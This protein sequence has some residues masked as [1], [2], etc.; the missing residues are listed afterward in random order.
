M[1][2]RSR[3]EGGRRAAARRESEPRK[4]TGGHN[5]KTIILSQKQTK[6]HKSISILRN[7]KK[8]KNFTP[9]PQKHHATS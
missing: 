9:A 3:L 5:S 7:G 8:I 2:E 4:R 1:N 6:S